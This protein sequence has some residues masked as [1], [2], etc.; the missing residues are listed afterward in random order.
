MQPGTVTVNIMPLTSF[1]FDSAG[2]HTHTLISRE[3]RKLLSGTDDSRSEAKAI[4][5]FPQ[6]VY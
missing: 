4:Q 6:N 2:K 1:C 3:R 5:I